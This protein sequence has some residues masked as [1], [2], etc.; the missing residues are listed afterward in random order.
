MNFLRNRSTWWWARVAGVLVAVALGVLLAVE[1]PLTAQS[2][3]S[4]VPDTGV[5]TPAH[6]TIGA[7]LRDFFNVHSTPEQPIAFTHKAHLAKGLVCQNCH[8]GVDTGAE[9]RIPNVSFC[10]TC[11]IAIDTNNP[12]IKQVAAYQARGEDIPWQRVYDFEPEYHVRFNHAP[13]IRAGV[14][15]S[16]CHGDMTQATVARRTVNLTM[17]FCVTCHRQEKVS[18]DCVTCHF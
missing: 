18:V 17:G 16:T 5:F 12:V 13:H 6:S 15:C 2:P 3:S 10:M 4:P 9:P 11:H 1:W 7:S 14:N 8:V